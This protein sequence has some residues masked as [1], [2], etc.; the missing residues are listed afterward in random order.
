MKRQKSASRERPRTGAANIF[1]RNR[2]KMVQL[3]LRKC[4][5]AAKV[6]VFVVVV[7]TMLVVFEQWRGGKRSARAQF[8]DTVDAEYERQVLEDEARIVPGLGDGGEAVQLVG[9][10]KRLGEASEKKLA[11]NVYLSDKIPYNRTLKGKSFL[12][13][14]L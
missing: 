14:T 3:P 13:S 6:C 4:Y 2:K 7:V 12:L 9:E 8:L 1:D 5:H 10:E 11:I